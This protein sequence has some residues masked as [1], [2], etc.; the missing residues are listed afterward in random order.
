MARATAAKFVHLCKIR[1]QKI[2][3]LQIERTL[4]HEFAR[5]LLGHVRAPLAVE[6]ALHER[7]AAARR[8]RRLARREAAERDRVNLRIENFELKNA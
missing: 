1:D 5:V 4:E 3:N 8:R 6:V 2:K 7:A